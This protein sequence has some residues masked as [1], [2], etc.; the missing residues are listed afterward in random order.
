MLNSPPPILF[1]LEANVSIL[2]KAI[3]FDC[4]FLASF[5]VFINEFVC[6]IFQNQLILPPPKKNDNK[7]FKSSFKP[8]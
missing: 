5:E 1:F 7:C 2:Y 4:L 6:G 8:L 3:N